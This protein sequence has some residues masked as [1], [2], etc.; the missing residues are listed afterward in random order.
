MAA[1][2]TEHCFCNP[3]SQWNFDYL[4]LCTDVEDSKTGILASGGDKLS[5]ITKGEEISISEWQPILPALINLEN[6]DV[7]RRRPRDCLAVTADGLGKQ[8]RC[9][10]LTILFLRFQLVRRHP[11]GSADG[12]ENR[13]IAA[14]L[15]NAQD[16]IPGHH[17]LPPLF[18]IQGV[19]YR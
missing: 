6:F 17:Q 19:K 2:R 11:V 12:Y 14:V 15:D 1:I 8:A 18:A 9:G 13:L 10:R 4:A 7:R 5:V 3:A 16:E